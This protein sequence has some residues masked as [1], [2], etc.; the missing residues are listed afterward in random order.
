MAMAVP[1]PNIKFVLAGLD[2]ATHAVPLPLA[3]PV[4]FETTVYS[5]KKLR[6]Q[7]HVDGRVKPGQ[8][9]AIW[10]DFVV[11]SRKST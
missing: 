6:S 11:P 9:K 5:R 10:S 2:P 7:N 1:D 3:A 8:D 4:G